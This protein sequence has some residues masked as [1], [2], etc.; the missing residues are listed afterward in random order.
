MAW[1]AIHI[2]FIDILK[3]ISQKERIKQLR[4]DSPMT[5]F[6]FP[7]VVG[8]LS[9]IF[10]INLPA[11]VQRIAREYWRNNAHYEKIG[12][13][14]MIIALILGFWATISLVLLLA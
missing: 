1:L 14:A 2:K 7:L 5:Y 11:E 4:K 12:H 8:V 10:W 13:A 9:L 6:I 3:R